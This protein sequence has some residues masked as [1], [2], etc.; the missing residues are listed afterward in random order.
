MGQV[1]TW[2]KNDWSGGVV[3][4][5]EG[6]I[7]PEIQA[8]TAKEMVNISILESGSIGQLFKVKEANTVY[9]LESGYT[10]NK[11]PSGE[12]VILKSNTY[13]TNRKICNIVTGASKLIGT[14]TGYADTLLWPTLDGKL[15]YTSIG[16]SN[17]IYEFK[18]YILNENGSTFDSEQIVRDSFSVEDNAFN[19]RLVSVVKWLGRTW[20]FFNPHRFG[21]IPGV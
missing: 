19:T 21:V 7:E 4:F 16:V 9:Q 8:K 1:F 5:S 6:R 11:Q 18:L 20:F 15:Y 17:F 13:P 3:P 12:F 14:Y 10:I 2:V